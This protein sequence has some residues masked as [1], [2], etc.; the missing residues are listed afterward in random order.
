MRGAM[1]RTN[2]LTAVTPAKPPAAY[3][4]GKKILSAEII[5]RIN[6]TPHTGYDAWWPAGMPA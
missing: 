6:A 3:I 1:A 4:G 2:Q 5:R